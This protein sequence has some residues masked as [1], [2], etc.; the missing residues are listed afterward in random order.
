MK[1]IVFTL[2]IVSLLTL[3]GCQSQQ[4][5]DSSV[6]D[7]DAKN[8]ALEEDMAVLEDALSKRDLSLCKDMSDEA[9][10]KL[11]KDRIEAL[12]KADSE[13]IEPKD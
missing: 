8:E 3:A 1:K 6:S 13:I 12:Q 10:V 2:C 4:S 9:N 5:D 11:C 7:V